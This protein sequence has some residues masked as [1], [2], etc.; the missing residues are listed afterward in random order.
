MMRKCCVLLAVLLLAVLFS[1][2]IVENGQVGMGSWTEGVCLLTE[3]GQVLLIAEGEP[4]ALSDR[5]KEGGLL[6]GLQTGE[7]IR[8]L[9]DGIAESFPARTGVYKLERIGQGSI[10][11]IPVQVLDTLRELGWIN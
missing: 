8:V 7:R 4:I 3:T 2:C 11:D 6:D 5:S 10:D 1:G 9:H